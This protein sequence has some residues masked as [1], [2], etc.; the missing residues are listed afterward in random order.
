MKLEVDPTNGSVM[1]AKWKLYGNY[2]GCFAYFKYM[3][4]KPETP[5]DLSRLR[6]SVEKKPRTKVGQIRTAWP[7][8]QRLLAGGHTLKD[9]HDSLGELG[10]EIGYPRLCEYINQLRR[11][12]PSMATPHLKVASVPAAIEPTLTLQHSAERDPLANVKRIQA[13][14]PGFHFRPFRAE[15]E[16]KLTGLKKT[17]S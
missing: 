9:V 11:E 17:E 13:N 15:D 14:R 10:I 6:N 1:E 4:R 12:Q 7:E 8:I 2:L 16:E 3:G 5:L